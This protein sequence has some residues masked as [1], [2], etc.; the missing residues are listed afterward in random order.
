M[1]LL[2]TSR[3]RKIEKNERAG[4]VYSEDYEGS[5]L[6]CWPGCRKRGTGG[7]SGVH[8]PPKFG[9]RRR[10]TAVFR[11]PRAA[12]GRRPNHW[13]GQNGWMVGCWIL[14]DTDGTTTTPCFG[15]TG[16][17]RCAVMCAFLKN[18]KRIA[19]ES[20]ISFIAHNYK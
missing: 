7:R 15:G 2:L 18:L 13:M 1:L 6:W 11:S 8:R 16:T 19:E 5:G 9:A 17:T 12:S 4:G 20:A 14:A 3:K 10:S